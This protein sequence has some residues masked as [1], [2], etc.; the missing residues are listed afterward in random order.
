MLRES[1]ETSIDIPA[2]RREL[3]TTSPMSSEKFSLI[4]ILSPRYAGAR[5][6]RIS[7]DFSK[8]QIT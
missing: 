6:T 7:C 1:C 3:A 5:E 2:T 4:D 8:E